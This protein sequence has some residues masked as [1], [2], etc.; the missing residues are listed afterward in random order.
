[1][2]G[3]PSAAPGSFTAFF[4]HGVGHI[5]TGRDH[6]LFLLVLVVAAPSLK[7]VV[8][9][10]TG[11]NPRSQPDAGAGRAGHRPAAP[12]IE[13]FIALSIVLVALENGVRLDARSRAFAAV[14]AIGLLGPAALSPPVM[15][16]MVVA[17]LALAGLCYAT[18]ML[19]TEQGQ[20]LRLALTA[21]FGLVRGFG[22]A[23]ELTALH[24]GPALLLPALLGFN[25]GV[26]GGQL[27]MLAAVWP[28][29]LLARRASL[30]AT[31]AASS[32]AAGIGVYRFVLR[33]FG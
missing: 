21:A 4:A 3:H 23:G 6:L 2:A 13:T 18:L 19:R 26:E 7:E 32:A 11:F 31:P 29:R 14:A 15:A 12:A 16:P 25:L 30:P 27:L 33:L 10:A 1:M 22:F 28:L 9:L 5:L 24:M 20:R 8:V 17:G